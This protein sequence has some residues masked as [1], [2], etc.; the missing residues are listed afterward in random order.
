MVLLCEEKT[1]NDIEVAKPNHIS[2]TND[3]IGMHNGK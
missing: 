3:V 1:S 2:F